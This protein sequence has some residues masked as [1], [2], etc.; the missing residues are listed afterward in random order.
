M[1]VDLPIH[2]SANKGLLDN[3]K[4]NEPKPVV[5]QI[6]RSRVCTKILESDAFRGTR[7]I[8]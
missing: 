3:A 4:F 2:F 1:S 6:A 8:E 7:D 5:L